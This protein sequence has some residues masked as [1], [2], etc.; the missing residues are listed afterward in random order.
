ML[1]LSKAVNYSILVINYLLSRSGPEI[2]TNA[3]LAE[4][5]D[6]PVDFLSKVLQKLTHSGIIKSIKGING[7]YTLSVDPSSITLKNIIESVDGPTSIV[8]DF[9]ENLKG[10]NRS[11]QSE[12]LLDTMIHFE[13][14]LNNL[15]E[16]VKF[17]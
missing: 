14:A 4:I 1:G 5:L 17:R 7:G 2:R 6:L 13:S 8:D 10:I 16:Q 11:E 9:K 12:P 15:L 3:E